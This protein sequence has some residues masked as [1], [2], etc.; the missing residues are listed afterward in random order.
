MRAP[1]CDPFR[2]IFTAVRC[3]DCSGMLHREGDHIACWR[4]GRQYRITRGIPELTPQNPSPRSPLHRSCLAS[5][6]ELHDA[7][8]DV[9]LDAFFGPEAPS[10]N[11]EDFQAF[12]R[13]LDAHSHEFATHTLGVDLACGT[14]PFSSYLL[15]MIPPLTFIGIDASMR[16][17][18][19]ARATSQSSR[20]HLIHGDILDQ[21]LA[22][23]T[24]DIV[25]CTWALQ[26]LASGTERDELLRLAFRS[27]TGC[28]S[29][30]TC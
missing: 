2:Q 22:E 3:P 12:F 21:R 19:A 6:I 26:F 24:F 29:E 16:T 14:C 15:A 4:C 10:D 28:C 17:L 25:L 5:A 23:D 1:R 11:R 13:F 27:L 7:I 18:F 20:L 8:S 30:G 9:V